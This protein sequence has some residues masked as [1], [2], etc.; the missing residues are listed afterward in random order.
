MVILFKNI[1]LSNIFISLRITAIYLQ[2]I[3][4]VT[5][6]YFGALTCNVQQVLMGSEVGAYVDLFQATVNLIYKELP[7]LSG[8][9]HIV[10]WYDI[11][12]SVYNSLCAQ[13]IFCDGSTALVPYGSNLSS[14]VNY[15]ISPLVRVMLSIPPQLYSIIVGILISDAWLQRPN[16]NRNARFG[17][18]QSM[19]HFKYFWSVFLKLSH[20]CS[21][22]PYLTKS[23]HKGKAYFGVGFTTRTLPC[24]TELHNLFY[25]NG[26]KIV[27]LNLFEILTPEALAHWICCDGSR[28]GGGI[29][30]HTQSFT[31]SL[32]WK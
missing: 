31:T 23:I 6:L 25:V 15:R 14:T 20:F 30:L 2:W 24:F 4:F 32:K 18:K 11:A 21:S 8:P 22:S 27:P 17:F 26:K 19:D 1:Q 12:V 10:E 9:S 13:T 5:L 16:I 28:T 29:T 3:I 7:V